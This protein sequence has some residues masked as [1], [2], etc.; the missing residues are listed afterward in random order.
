MKAEEAEAGVH[1]EQE[2]QFEDR[3]NLLSEENQVLFEQVESYRVQF[4]A[5]SKTYEERM[6][7]MSE[8]ISQ[9]DNVAS[10]ADSSG[11]ALNE[12]RAQLDFLQK[13]MGEMA[14]Q[15]G[16]MEVEVQTK[17]SDIRKLTME[18]Q[19]QKEYHLFYKGYI[20]AYTKMKKRI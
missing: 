17:D 20:F 5:L 12:A 14:A 9:Y 7:E 18:L 19:T 3:L 10:E 8:K 2:Q 4:D 11:K 1:T 13:R 16:A 6:K 15:T